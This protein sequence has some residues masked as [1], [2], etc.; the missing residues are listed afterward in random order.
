MLTRA[1]GAGG[2]PAWRGPVW[3]V[4]AV[5][6]DAL[7]AHVRSPILF[8]HARDDALGVVE[9]VART[10]PRAAIEPFDGDHGSQALLDGDAAADVAETKSDEVRRLVRR[11]MQLGS[12]EP[13][14]TPGAAHAPSVRSLLLGELRSR[15]G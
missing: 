8:S 11:A 3:M 10:L 2:A 9:D 1:T 14:K 6:A 15:N 4:S 12:A 5:K 13:S 7:L